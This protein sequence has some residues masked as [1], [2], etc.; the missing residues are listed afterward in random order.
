VLPCSFVSVVSWGVNRIALPT[1]LWSVIAIRNNS[2]HFG[3]IRL[4]FAYSYCNLH[5]FRF[6]PLGVLL[7]LSPLAGITPCTLRDTQVYGSKLSPQSKGT[8]KFSLNNR[9]IFCMLT[10]NSPVNTSELAQLMRYSRATISSHKRAGYRFEFGNRT[11]AGHYKAWLRERAATKQR[12]VSATV[13]R[14]RAVLA[15]LR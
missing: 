3:R 5:N 6:C 8:P 7:G 11:T 12:Q 1:V 4:T 14:R 13:A 2:S 10:D 15:T 9:T